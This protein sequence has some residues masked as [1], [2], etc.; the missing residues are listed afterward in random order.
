MSRLLHQAGTPVACSD[1]LTSRRSQAWR[2]W[3]GVSDLRVVSGPGGCRF[4][5]GVVIP[6][7]P[8]SHMKIHVNQYRNFHVSYHV[9]NHLVVVPESAIGQTEQAGDDQQ[10]GGHM[11]IRGDSAAVAYLVGAELSARRAQAHKTIADAAKALGCSNAKVHNMESGRNQQ[12]PDE[13]ET[14]VR[15]YGSSQVDIDR[16]CALAA[17]A[18]DRAAWWAPWSDVVP[19]WLKTFVGLEGLATHAHIY[20]P[21]VLPALVQTSGYSLAATEGDMRVRAD[22]NDRVVALRQERQR[23]VT[24]GEDPLE[25][26]VFIEEAALDRPM[27]PPEVMTEQYQHLLELGDLPN[28]SLRLLPISIGRHDAIAGRFVLLDFAEASSIAYVEMRHGAVYLQE[29]RVVDGYAKT[30]EQLRD[31]ALSA[32]ATAE[33]IKERINA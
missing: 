20:A 12:R 16:L 19:D 28:V 3:P 32:A 4:P 7:T 21:Q 17:S 1:R 14:L 30:V 22:H 6:D 9:E 33:A 24:E 15:F 5:R 18:D 26:E 27:G 31:V 10:L 11:A 8:N 25:L 2:S 13:V 23:R 29:S